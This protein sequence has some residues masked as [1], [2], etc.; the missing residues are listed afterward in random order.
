MIQTKDIIIRVTY[1]AE[2]L[3]QKGGN[4]QHQEMKKPPN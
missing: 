1:F 4:M 2:N 3:I